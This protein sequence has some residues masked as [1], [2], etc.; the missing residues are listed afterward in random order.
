MARKKEFISLTELCEVTG[1]RRAITFDTPGFPDPKII[2][3]E[4][5]YPLEEA[6]KFFKVESLDEPFIDIKEVAEI[7]NIPWQTV[8]TWILNDK[9]KELPYCSLK[10]GKRLFRKSEVLKFKELNKNLRQT[11][12]KD[13]KRGR[14]PKPIYLFDLEGNFKKEYP[15]AKCASLDL[16]IGR[17]AINMSVVQNGCCDGKYYFRRSKEFEFSKKIIRRKRKIGYPLMDADLSNKISL[18]ELSTVTGIHNART[19]DTTE[20]F[21]RPQILEGEYFY[22]LEEVCKFFKVDSLDEPFIDIN[23]VAEILNIKWHVVQVWATKGRFPSYS[24]KNIRGSRRL[25]RKSEVLKFQKEFMNYKDLTP[26]CDFINT[27]MARRELGHILYEF[28]DLQ[29]DRFISTIEKDILVSYFQN[30][31]YYKK[32]C[33]RHNLTK[34]RVRQIF[35]QAMRRLRSHMERLQ[36]DRVGRIYRENEYLKRGGSKNITETEAMD[37]QIIKYATTRI[38]N[39]NLPSRAIKALANGDIIYIYELLLFFHSYRSKCFSKIR[40][41]GVETARE[42]ELFVLDQIEQFNTYGRGSF[43]YL[44]S[45]PTISGKIRAKIQDLNSKVFLKTPVDT[46]ENTDAPTFEIPKFDEVPSVRNDDYFHK[47]IKYIKK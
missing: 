17:N 9:F 35:D 32:M 3:G 6:C 29:G 34:E 1:V 13:M 28:L 7:L 30:K 20:D 12:N 41:I 43:E 2:R 23:E 25:F 26:D 40:N 15:N 4:L 46:G 33:E 47:S 44:F 39:F 31:D 8:R 42:I 45:S 21:P 5:F 37:T 16:N 27:F 36:G 22:P 38:D 10:G 24:L 18:K 11:A 14:V 19:Y